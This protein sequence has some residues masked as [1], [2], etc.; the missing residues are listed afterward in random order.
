PYVGP[1]QRV[2]DLL[3]EEKASD[4]RYAKRD[5]RPDQPHAQLDQMLDQRRLGR[6]DLFLVFFASHARP[7]PPASFGAT[8][9]DDGSGGPVRK[10]FA[11]TGGGG[12]GNGTDTSGKGAAAAG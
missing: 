8:A 11:V 1:C 6:L 2:V 3:S 9:G 10:S 4:E 5:E 12:A 7:P